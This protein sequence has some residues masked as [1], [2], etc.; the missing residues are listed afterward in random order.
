VNGKIVT[1]GADIDIG[2]DEK[3]KALTLKDFWDLLDKEE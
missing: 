1:E 3:Y 2:G